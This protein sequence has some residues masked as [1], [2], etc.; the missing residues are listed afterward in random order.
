MVFGN[1]NFNSPIGVGDE[2]REEVEKA[3]GDLAAS[4]QT[5]YDY[6]GQSIATQEDAQLALDAINNAIVEKDKIR[7]HL[8]ATQNRLENTV[9]NPHHPVGKPPER[10][11]P[12][13]RRRRGHRNDQ[14][15]AQ[16]GAHAVGRGHALAGQLHA[17]DGHAAHRLVT[18]HAQ[19]C[20]CSGG[21]TPRRTDAYKTSFRDIPGRRFVIRADM[22]LSQSFFSLK[23]CALQT[24]QPVVFAGKKSGFFRL[25]SGR[26]AL[27]RRLAAYLFQRQNALKILCFLPNL[28]RRTA[29]K[30][31]EKRRQRRGQP[32]N[33]IGAD[34]AGAHS[35]AG[36]AVLY[37]IFKPTCRSR[38]NGAC[39]SIITVW[40]PTWPTR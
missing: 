29:E 1:I 22:V 4:L 24:I 23:R 6:G 33:G 40:P 11:I 32:L 10:R 12:H 7:A 31:D 30:T 25:T 18:K 27:C 34:A 39:I 15:R 14:L 13:P 38:R 16:S 20:R 21:G 9:T 28:Y 36:N 26:T 3:L 8:G 17:A 2:G 5:K 19:A 35:I 37:A